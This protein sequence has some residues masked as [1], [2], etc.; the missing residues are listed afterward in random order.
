[1]NIDDAK[2]KIQNEE[3]ENYCFFVRRLPMKVK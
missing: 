1:M 2:K 3:L